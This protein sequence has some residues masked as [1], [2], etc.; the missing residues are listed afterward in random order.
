MDFLGF[1]CEE[2]FRTLSGV[3]YQLVEDMPMSGRSRE[4]QNARLTTFVGTIEM[5]WSANTHI[6]T[7]VRI[8]IS[9]DKCGAVSRALLKTAVEG[10][11]EQNGISKLSTFEA[12]LCPIDTILVVEN[13]VDENGCAD[14]V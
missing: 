7:Y 8:C 1:R 11:L 3:S 2:H 12:G 4:L 9:R 13:R 14:R 6:K 10:F 5:H